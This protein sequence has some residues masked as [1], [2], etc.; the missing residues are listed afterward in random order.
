MQGLDK[1]KNNTID[2]N[3]FMFI[4]GK[5][6]QRHRCGAVQNYFDEIRETISEFESYD[7]I[8][9]STKIFLKNKT[10][11]LINHI[12]NPNK[13]LVLSHLA[14]IRLISKQFRVIYLTNMD[15][16]GVVFDNI[17]LAGS[18]LWEGDFSNAQFVDCH[19][20]DTA[21]NNCNLTNTKFINCMMHD[22]DLGGMN[23]ETTSFIRCDISNWR[24][25]YSKI[26]EQQIIKN[27]NL[28]DPPGIIYKGA[29]NKIFGRD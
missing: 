26:N 29:G 1:I 17:D 2:N 7:D 16:T 3:A 28:Y 15:F 10:H 27:N 18:I 4:V 24:L 23:M 20:F 6:R 5:S 14:G 8:D 11:N 9:L 21:F 22:N 13:A 25:L 12:S 19:L